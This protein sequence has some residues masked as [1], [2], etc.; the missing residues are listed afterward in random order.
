[1]IR[2]GSDLDSDKLIYLYRITLATAPNRMKAGPELLFSD[3]TGCAC[4]PP[5]SDITVRVYDG[6]VLRFPGD[7]RPARPPKP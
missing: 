6:Q 2:C 1:M 7:P 5:Q 4:K 3:D